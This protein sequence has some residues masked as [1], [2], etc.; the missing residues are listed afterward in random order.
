MMITANEHVNLSFPASNQNQ[1][2]LNFGENIPPNL[3]RN[4]TS[5]GTKRGLA[6]CREELIESWQMGLSTSHESF[7]SMQSDYSTDD[8]G[9]GQ[10][11]KRRKTMESDASFMQP[12]VVS[13]SMVKA[14]R[15]SPSNRPQKQFEVKAGWYDGDV[16][17]AGNRHGKGVTKHD[18]GTQY[19]GP[20][21]EDV[22]DGFGRY[23]FLTERQMIQTGTHQT[24]LH[25]QIEKSFEGVFKNDQPSGMGR[26]ITKT[27][28]TT[29]QG[30][31]NS[32]QIVYDY[33]YHRANGT[34]VGEGVRYIFSKNQ[35][36]GQWEQSC[37]RMNSGTTTNV[38]LALDYGKWVCDCLGIESPSPP[39]QW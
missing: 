17:T 21:R 9:N 10:S 31:V 23:N 30:Q 1:V 18:D 35:M 33:G 24:Y 16:D 22:M 13:D 2:G 4:R 5:I 12:E 6:S 7:D 29:P 14:M 19:E 27:I 36:V 32:I 25:R 39:T 20:Y 8:Q 3:S 37:F 15:I 11:F 28:D 34:A 26:M 38:R